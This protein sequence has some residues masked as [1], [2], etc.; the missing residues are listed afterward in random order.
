MFKT[1]KRRWIA[2]FVT[3]LVLGVATAPVSVEAAGLIT[4][5]Q[6]E[7]N[8]ITSVDL[9]THAVRYDDL[10]PRL[11]GYFYRLYERTQE[12]EAVACQNA[13]A[14]PANPHPGAPLVIPDGP[15]AS[16]NARELHERCAQFPVGLRLLEQL[17]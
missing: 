5:R 16:F 15:V 17:P 9:R 6:I 12:L 11:Q 8:S 3:G 10:S 2:A 4:G 13:D 1:S 7:D 14:P